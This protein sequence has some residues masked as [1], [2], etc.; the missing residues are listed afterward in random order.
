[1]SVDKLVDSTQLDSD[2]TSVANAIR[3]KG[4][5][6]AQL[7]FPSGFV[8]AIGN[9]PSGGGGADLSPIAASKTLN[10]LSGLFDALDNDTGW[11]YVEYSC[12]S[13]TANCIV[14]FGRA[15]KGLIIYPKSTS[16][17]DLANNERQ[18]LGAVVFNDPDG[19]GI[20][21][22]IWQVYRIKNNAKNDSYINRTG[23]RTL[24]NGVLT[25]PY[26]YSSNNSYHPFGFGIP[27][28]FVYWW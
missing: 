7:A 6:S 18:V 12:T 3:T 22:P 1:M 28:L 2:L 24:Q 19:D 27:Y 5:T 15:I 14:D 25:A 9:I 17:A 26:N 4:G 8:S 20:Q 10:Q 11:G 21:S 23:S 13:G 16:F